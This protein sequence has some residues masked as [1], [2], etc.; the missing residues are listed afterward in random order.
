MLGCLNCGIDMKLTSKIDVETWLKKYSVQNYTINE[1][2]SVDVNG[3]VDLDNKYLVEI[4][5]Q[6][7]NVSG[8]FNCYSNY[9]TDLSG[10]PIK[11]GGSF[12]CN[13]NEIVVSLIGSPI[14]IGGSFYCN[15]GNYTS[16]EGCPKRVVGDFN[17]RFNKLVSLDDGPDF[18]G[19]E[20]NCK[21]NNLCENDSFL[22]ECSLSQVQQYYKNKDLKDFLVNTMDSVIKKVTGCKI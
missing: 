18:V 4:K 9:L 12:C 13:G 15:N 2:M 7:R 1:D 10:C 19:R 14:E 3:N 20:F 11:I 8:D 6:F 5:V 22:Y 17:F 21:D 16:L